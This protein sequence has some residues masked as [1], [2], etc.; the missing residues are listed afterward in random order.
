MDGLS[1]IAASAK[2]QPPT[3]VPLGHG[4]MATC[5]IW[6]LQVAYCQHCFGSTH[7][8]EQC[9][10]APDTPPSER[11]VFLPQPCKPR[12]CREWNYTQCTFPGCQYIHAC[13]TCYN[14]PLLRDSN[15][16]LIHCPKNVNRRQGP[17]VLPLM[18]TPL[19]YP[20]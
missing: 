13:L 1:M 19:Q 3:W 7:S 14:D 11:K 18:G 9:S 5:G 17:P 12:I 16:K 2:L 6:P 10:G 15:Y 20:H 4:E 8:S